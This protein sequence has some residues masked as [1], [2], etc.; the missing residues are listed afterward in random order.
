MDIEVFKP[1][2]KITG[3]IK[4]IVS[5]GSRMMR[6]EMSDGRVLISLGIHDDSANL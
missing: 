6:A 2:F 5:S 3:N 1:A 4:V